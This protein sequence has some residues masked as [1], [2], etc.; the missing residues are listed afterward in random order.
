M[1]QDMDLSRIHPRGE[2]TRPLRPPSDRPE[3]QRTEAPWVLATTQTVADPWG[4]RPPTSPHWRMTEFVR[5]N[6]ALHRAAFC[7]RWPR[8]LARVR[9]L[10]THQ[11][12]EGAVEWVFPVA[13]RGAHGFELVTIGRVETNDIVLDHH[14]VSKSHATLCE[15]DDGWTLTDTGSTNGTVLDRTPLGPHC[16]TR[17]GVGSRAVLGEVALVELLDSRTV[18]DR[19]LA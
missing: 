11:A 12:P 10:P 14:A 13:R 5:L 8:L 18:F 3:R 16:A 7:A 6:R 2:P 19:Y 4:G 15:Q 1:T 17:V 9:W